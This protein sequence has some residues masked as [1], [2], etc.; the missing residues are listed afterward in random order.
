LG[1]HLDIN[2]IN[3]RK[4]KKTYSDNMWCFQLNPV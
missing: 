3:S 1:V 2:S 4:A